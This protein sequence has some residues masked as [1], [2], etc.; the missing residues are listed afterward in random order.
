MRTR[1]NPW[2]ACRQS[3]TL[4]TSCKDTLD[5]IEKRA[6][7]LRDLRKRQDAVTTVQ[8]AREVLARG[9][10]AAFAFLY[11]EAMAKFPAHVA[12]RAAA[13]GAVVGGKNKTTRARDVRLAAECLDAQ[14]KTGRR[15]D[16]RKIAAKENMRI[17]TVR[18]AIARGKKIIGKTG[19]NS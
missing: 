3:W 9:D 12:G 5:L 13:A 6:Q 15:P 19:A 16:Y 2:A 14:A 18:K 11:G 7:N 10:L 1:R 4:I 8:G 17:E